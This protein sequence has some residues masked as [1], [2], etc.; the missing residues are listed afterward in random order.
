M[1]IILVIQECG[2]GTRRCHCQYP[3]PSLFSK[4]STFVQA[5]QALSLPYMYGKRSHLNTPLVIPSTIWRWKLRVMMK[6]GYRR[7]DDHRIIA[8]DTDALE[9]FRFDMPDS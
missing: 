6:T 1:P 2:H 5:K 3:S 7:E 4:D 8:E 9:M